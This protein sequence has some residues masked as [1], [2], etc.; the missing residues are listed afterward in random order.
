MTGVPVTT[1]ISLPPDT[2]AEVGS[3]TTEADP[4]DGPTPDESF[5]VGTVNDRDYDELITEEWFAEHE[6]EIYA[7]IG[8]DGDAAAAAIRVYDRLYV[9]FQ[10]LFNPQRTN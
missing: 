9:E 5:E 3:I 7:D 1:L 4:N 2:F 10:N 6:S 8:D